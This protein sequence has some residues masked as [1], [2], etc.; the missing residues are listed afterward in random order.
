MKATSKFSTILLLWDVD[1]TLLER[2]NN[3]RSNTHLNAVK[4]H[5]NLNDSK[6]LNPKNYEFNGKTDIEILIEILTSLKIEVS[7][8]EFVQIVRE[9]EEITES[10]TTNASF[11]S[12]PGINV[13]LKDCKKNNMTNGILTGNTL[14]R[15]LIKL[16]NVDILNNFDPRYIYTADEKLMSEKRRDIIKKAY[17]ENL[18]KFKKI[19]FIGDSFYEC[20]IFN[21]LGY[22]YVAICKNDL[23]LKECFRLNPNLTFNKIPM[24]FLDVIGKI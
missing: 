14:K 23:D 8:N 7:A 16:Q 17:T 12:L 20:S 11:K 5:F 22:N 3:V 6:F 1:N 24:N 19:I 15:C 21:E 9:L 10:D 18:S 2:I 4:K 13:T